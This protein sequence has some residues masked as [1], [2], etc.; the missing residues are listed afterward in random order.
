[1]DYIFSLID[2]PYQFFQGLGEELQEKYGGKKATS[3]YTQSDCLYNFCMRFLLKDAD[4]DKREECFQ[5]LEIIIN[6]DFA[7]S[8]NIRKWKR[9]L[10]N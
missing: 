5:E 2:S 4:R 7:L 8:G 3:S 6:K 1:M 9:H 10:P